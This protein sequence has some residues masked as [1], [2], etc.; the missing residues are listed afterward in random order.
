MKIKIERQ[1]Y[2]KNNYIKWLS[3]IFLEKLKQ[4]VILTFFTETFKF[5]KMCIIYSL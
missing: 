1:H 5:F 3:S 2:P 4:K